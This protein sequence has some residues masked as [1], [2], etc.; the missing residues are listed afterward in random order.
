MTGRRGRGAS[1]SWSARGRLYTEAVLHGPTLAGHSGGYA[2]NCIGSHYV[3]R[4]SAL[5][6]IGGLGPELAEDFTTTLMMSSHG[7]Q[8]V[9]AVDAEAHGDGPETVSDCV[10]RSSSGRA[11]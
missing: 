7:W 4:T 11:A 6:E 1:R 9:F 10:R 5:Q 8:G 2:P 3:V